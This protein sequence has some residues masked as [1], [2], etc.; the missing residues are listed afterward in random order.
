[1]GVVVGYLDYSHSQSTKIP[2]TVFKIKW[3]IENGWHFDTQGKGLH[4]VAYFVG[5]QVSNKKFFYRYLHYN[6]KFWAEHHG[7]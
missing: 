1:M 5:D 7:G 6:G 2:P 3:A 4:S